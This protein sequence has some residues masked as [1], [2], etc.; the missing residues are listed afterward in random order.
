MKGFKPIV[1]I[2]FLISGVTCQKLQGQA[3]IVAM[4]FGD[5]V[6]SEEFNLGFELG[7]NWSDY[8]N[9]EGVRGKHAIRIGMSGNI[10]L[11]ESF[12]LSPAIYF[13]S[14][15][16]FH[17]KNLSLDT[18]NPLFDNEFQNTGGRGQLRYV[19]LPVMTWFALDKWRIGLGPQVSFLT[20]SNLTFEGPEGNFERDIE[21]NTNAI[22]YGI[23]TGLSYELGKARKGKGIFLQLRYYQGF[24]D[25]FEDSL[26]APEN[27][28]H[29]FAVHVSLPFITEELA[30]KN[31]EQ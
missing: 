24:S 18:G 26:L 12:Y 16:S 17:F 8:S 5:Q 6:A 14:Q 30:Q 4:L 11:S 1:I 22:D 20:S 13:L 15:R 3:A 21:E 7:M 19:D 23:M 9:I 31:L 29:F 2:L 28:Q 10:K 27:K 25:I